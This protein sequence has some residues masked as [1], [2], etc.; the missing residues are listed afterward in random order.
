MKKKSY[1][2]NFNGGGIRVGRRCC[3]EEFCEIGETRQKQRRDRRG[4]KEK[5]KNRNVRERRERRGMKE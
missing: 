1:K 4:M 5:R 3:R 2:G